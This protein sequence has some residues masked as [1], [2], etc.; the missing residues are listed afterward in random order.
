MSS[1]RVK[2]EPDVGTELYCRS[3]CSEWLSESLLLVMKPACSGDHPGPNHQE[4]RTTA[5]EH[6]LEHVGPWV[7]L[8]LMFVA[9]VSESVQ[10]DTM[11]AGT[12]CNLEE[13]NG[14]QLASVSQSLSFHS[15][16]FILPHYHTLVST[17]ASARPVLPT[18]THPASPATALPPCP[19][20]RA[21]ICLPSVLG[22]LSLSLS[23]SHR[24]CYRQPQ[25]VGFSCTS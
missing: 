14:E 20:A 18:N 24:L 21:A 12:T 13:V 19:H 6:Q 23:S 16:S 5:S 15:P 9:F 2:N 10:E 3:H 8:W 11:R 22:L 1:I 7:T 25:A 4:I 17:K